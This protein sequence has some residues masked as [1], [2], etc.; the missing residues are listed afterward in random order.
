MYGRKRL[1][2]LHT[3]RKRYADL[4]YCLSQSGADV[5]RP[6]CAV[7]EDLL[8]RA[9]GTPEFEK[10][11]QCALHGLRAIAQAHALASVWHGAVHGK[12]ARYREPE[13]SKRPHLPGQLRRADQRHC[14]RVHELSRGDRGPAAQQQLCWGALA[15][16]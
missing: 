1:L 6:C 5:G 4:N 11:K 13:P 2:S 7:A 8:E 15:A 14:W 10:K 3:S 9:V 12:Q 16:S